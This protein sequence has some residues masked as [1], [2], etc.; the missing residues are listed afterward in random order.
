[1]NSLNRIRSTV[2]WLLG[3]LA[4]LVDP[5]TSSTRSWR[6]CQPV[7]VVHPPDP[8]EEVLVIPTGGDPESRAVG[9]SAEAMRRIGQERHANGA[10]MHPHPQTWPGATMACVDCGLYACCC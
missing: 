7:Q 2:S 5:D 1:M 3:L 8:V 6:P 10:K 4:D 9:I